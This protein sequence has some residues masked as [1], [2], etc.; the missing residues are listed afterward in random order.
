MTTLFARKQIRDVDQVKSPNVFLMGVAA[1]AGV[2]LLTAVARVWPGNYLDLETLIG[3]VFTDR[4]DPLTRKIG[5]VVFLLIS[6][7]SAFGYSFIFWSARRSGAWIGAQL[8]LFHYLISG[9]LVGIFPAFHPHIPR[10]MV[11]PGFYMTNM[12]FTTSVMFFVAHIAYGALFGQLFDWA[13][14]RD[15]FPQPISSTGRTI[16]NYR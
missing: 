12:G 14:I 13:A 9:F 8:A 11:P 1:G 16:Q 15:E 2:L 6:G 5:L 7:I 4:I 10:L 3:S